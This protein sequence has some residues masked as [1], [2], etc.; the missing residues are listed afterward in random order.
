MSVNWIWDWWHNLSTISLATST[1]WEIC[2][3]INNI[4]LRSTSN[5][6]EARGTVHSFVRLDLLVDP[7]FGCFRSWFFATLLRIVTL[8]LWNGSYALETESKWA[9]THSFHSSLLE[10]SGSETSFVT[11]DTIIPLTLCY[12]WLTW[13]YGTLWALWHTVKQ[14]ST[15]WRILSHHMLRLLMLFFH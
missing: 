13:V 2:V 12:V 3:V 4:P 7:D 1:S 6:A 8:D 15:W 11:V 10:T 14:W 9:A 5:V